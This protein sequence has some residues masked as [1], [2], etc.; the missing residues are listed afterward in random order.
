MNKAYLFALPQLLLSA[1]LL[2]A[3]LPAW[4]QDTDAQHNQ[5]TIRGFATET[6]PGA[7]VGAAYLAL[8]NHTDVPR[9]LRSIVLPQHPQ[10]TASLHTTEHHEGISRMRAVDALDVPAQGQLEM[11]PG[12]LHVMLHGVR[13]HSGETLPIQ[14]IFADGQ[15]LEFELPVKSLM[16]AKKPRHHHD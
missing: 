1:T 5:L 3:T 10:A 12:G 15:I 9:S 11:Q 4:A 7:S 6:P 8:D 16:S 13:L 14:L 2:F